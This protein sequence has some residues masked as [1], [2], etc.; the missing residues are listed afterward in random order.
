M[1]G[2]RCPTVFLGHVGSGLL[3]SEELGAGEEGAVAHRV[4]A[5]LPHA[6]TLH[7]L[8]CILRT[9]D[10]AGTV[11]WYSHEAGWCRGGPPPWPAPLPSGA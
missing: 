5:G 7:T 4:E 11:P 6:H 2:V 3:D 8:N 1:H 9:V 10:G